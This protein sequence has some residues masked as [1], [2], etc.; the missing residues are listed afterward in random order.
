MKRTL[1]GLIF[2]AVIFFFLAA[3]A[4]GFLLILSGGDVVNFVRTTIIR[5][6]LSS[7]QEDLN[8]PIGSNETPQRFTINV[9]DT[10]LTIALN[11]TNAG[12][13]S[14]AQLFVDYVRVEQLDSQLEAGIY[15]LNQTQT[16]PEI[17]LLLTDSRS[18][19]I[20]FRI[21]EG[22]RIEEIADLIDQNR[23]FNFTGSDFEAMVGIG[24]QIDPTF[25]A[26]MGIPV[27]A[28]LEGF[29]FPSTYQLPPDITPESLRDTLL[30]AFRT[31]VGTQLLLDIQAQG[32]TMRDAVILA[33]IVE[34]E[35]V[36][37]DEHP[38][39]ASVYR[40]RLAIGMR[41]EADPTV[42]YALNGTRGRW[43]VNISIADYRGVES[44]YNTYLN[45]G[46]PPGPIANPGI[47]AIRAAVHPAE[48]SYYFFRA[49]C[50]GS[51]YHI[52]AT[53]YDE[54]LANGC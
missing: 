47:S 5:V 1:A 28:S 34:R 17:A 36:W 2:I 18:S 32:L 19:H 23:L 46:L 12:L 10:P 9:G 6:S 35:A 11:L 40:N 3:V 48:S 54:H 13:I 38:M 26:E 15:F 20:P 27:G 52:F 53:T 43:W 8:R 33:S 24:T 21:L 49:K 42:Q 22:T 7:R 37:D 30:E 51:N 45:T 31:N 39:I 14:D 44:P 25:A 29:L 41:L 50:D 4:G 16:I